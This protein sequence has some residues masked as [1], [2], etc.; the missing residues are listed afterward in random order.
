MRSEAS[1]QST[2]SMIS[3]QDPRLCSPEH[4]PAVVVGA[5]RELHLV[6]VAPRVVHA[7]DG[8]EAV[9][10]EVREALQRVHDLLLLELQLGV[11]GERLPLAAAALLRV[12]AAGGHA[13]RGGGEDLQRPRLGVRLLALGD[14]GAHAV[15]GHRAAHE[16]DELVH[17]RDALPAVGE[18][19]DVELDRC[20]RGVV[21]WSASVPLPRGTSRAPAAGARDVVSPDDAAVHPFRDR[22]PRGRPEGVSAPAAAGRVARGPSGLAARER[23]LT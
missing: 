22:P 19:G 18:A 13:A 2:T 20:L 23:S 5:E 4:E 14:A 15:A 1:S 17:P 12:A 3:R 11:V 7:A 16:D 9:L 21:A 8:L 6:A 10:G